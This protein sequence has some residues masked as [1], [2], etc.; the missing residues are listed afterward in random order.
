MM[1]SVAYAVKIK[2]N[3][4]V[5]AKLISVVTPLFEMGHKLDESPLVI[6]TTT[7]MKWVPPRLKDNL[8][9]VKYRNV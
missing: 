7:N 5:S 3:N 9:P 8:I 2:I 1:L 4:F 6:E